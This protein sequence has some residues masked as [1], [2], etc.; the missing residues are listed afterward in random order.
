MSIRLI[1]N[2]LRKKLF[3]P[4][5]YKYISIWTG[6]YCPYCEEYNNIAEG[7]FLF[8]YGRSFYEPCKL[9]N[10]QAAVARCPHCDETFTMN[11]QRER[12]K[13]I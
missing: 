8:M 3:C 5:C 4:K 7:F 2:L 9:C 12:G 10:R 11:S 1:K 6:W 13:V